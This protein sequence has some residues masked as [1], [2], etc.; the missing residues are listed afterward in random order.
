MDRRRY[1]I[2]LFLAA[3]VAVV[4]VVVSIPERRS[5]RTPTEEPASDAP[6]R[7][8]S[9]SAENDVVRRRVGGVAALSEGERTLVDALLARLRGPFSDPRIR[10]AF[11]ERLAAELERRHPE[12]WLAELERILR[13]AFPDDAEALLALF[14]Q[15]AEFQA[16]LASHRGEV[17]RMSPDARRDAMWEARRRHFGADADRIFA[18]VARNEA[19]EDTLA[20]I[21]ANPAGTVGDRFG[22]YVR[23]IEQSYGDDADDF[24]ANRRQELLDRFVGLNSIQAELATMPP[25]ERSEVLRGIRVQSGMDDEALGRWDSLDAERDDRAA[26]GASY[27][28][29]RAALEAAFTGDAL[30]TRLAALR[31][32]LFG[33]E[34]E[35]I[36]N[37]EAGG[38]FRFTIARAYGMN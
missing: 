16:W 11:L 23:S 35:T 6:E 14:R 29:R 30:A 13:A 20:E 31:A 7:A 32:E 1:A 10:L 24:V 21:D 25:A 27:M 9:V 18:S 26:R 5:A 36:A 15:R 3:S 34:A 37:E 2:V 17:A 8:P 38:Y 28:E 4:G 22:S 19:I 33:A 12:T